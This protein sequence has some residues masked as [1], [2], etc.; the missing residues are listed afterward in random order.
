M[1]VVSEKRYQHTATGQY[2]RRD[3]T[4]DVLRVISNNEME[5]SAKSRVLT[6]TLVPPGIYADHPTSH[7]KIKSQ[8]ATRQRCEQDLFL[9]LRFGEIVDRPITAL[10]RHSAS[11]AAISPGFRFAYLRQNTNHTQPLSVDDDFCTRV[12]L[13]DE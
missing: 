1:A 3:R 7:C 9:L 4:L 8:A 2:E 13:K 11:V 6:N 5:K 12:F 10:M